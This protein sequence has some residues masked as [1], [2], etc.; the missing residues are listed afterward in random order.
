MITEKQVKT[1]ENLFDEL[2]K[3][4]ADMNFDYVHM[5]LTNVYDNGF[6]NYVKYAKEDGEYQE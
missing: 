1:A 4:L 3:A 2:F 6:Q 5:M